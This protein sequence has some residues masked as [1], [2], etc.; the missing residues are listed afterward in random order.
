[1]KFKMIIERKLKEENMP[2]HFITSCIKIKVINKKDV[3]VCEEQLYNS[4]I[5]INN[6]LFYKIDLCKEHYLEFEQKEKKKRE[7][8]KNSFEKTDF[9]CPECGKPVFKHRHVRHGLYPEYRWFWCPS[10]CDLECTNCGHSD[11]EHCGASFCLNMSG[12]IPKIKE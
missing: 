9:K 4:K 3:I 7:I 5:I 1:M 6:G 2:I 10:F 8:E 12:W 11:G